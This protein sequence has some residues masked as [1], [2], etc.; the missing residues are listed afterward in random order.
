MRYK[1]LIFGIHVFL[2]ICIVSANLSWITA[3]DAPQM[4]PE[5]SIVPNLPMPD[6]P[7]LNVLGDTQKSKILDMPLL[8]VTGDVQKSPQILPNSNVVIKAH[9]QEKA[10]SKQPLKK[11]HEKQGTLVSHEL[12]YQVQNLT[13]KTVYVA[14]FSYIKK[15]IHGRWHWDKSP[16]YKLDHKDQVVIDVETVADERDRNST[17]GYLGVFNKEAAAEDATYELLPDVKKIDLDLLSHLQNKKVNLE[18]ERYGIAGEFYEY[19]FVPT[20][21]SSREIPKL[22][23]FVENQTGKTVHVVGFIYQKKAKGT[24]LASKTRESWDKD[25]EARDDM[26]VW[27]FDK[28]P[29]VTIKPHELGKIVV[30]TIVEG[31]DRSYVRGYLAIFEEDERAEAEKAVYELLSHRKRLKLGVLSNLKDKKVAITVKQYGV[32]GE[33]I[34]YIVK[35]IHHIDFEKIGKVLTS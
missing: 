9:V 30:D 15:R 18:V 17:F 25:L 24:W 16:V 12:D 6:M 20:R 29:I 26:S 11:G 3:S 8:N 21:A 13:G 35:P 7:L 19:D 5:P 2:C 10:L 33:R 28:T 22:D 23:F 27:R 1:N 32:S 31:R 34:D 4:K 14:G